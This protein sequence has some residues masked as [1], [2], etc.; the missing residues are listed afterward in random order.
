MAYSTPNGSTV[1]IGALS[2][3]NLT[4]TIATNAAPCVMTATAHGL[5]NGDYVTVL[6]SG[7]SRINEKTYRVSGVTTNTFELE[8]SDTSSVSNFPAGSGTGTV[9][10]VSSW[11][12]LTQILN[13]Q[14]TASEQQYAKYQPMDSD[15]EREIP[16]YKT[17]G[18]LDI[19]VGDDPTL[20]G[21]INAMAANDS[22]VPKPVR[23]TNK[24]GSKTLTYS[25]VSADKVAQMQVNEVQRSKVSLRHLNEANRY[26]T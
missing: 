20:A 23:I 1:D 12:P 26:A 9:Q 2:G 8:G 21:F 4:V 6:T 5:T 7:W 16:T 19:E 13:I 10:K 25:Y 17:G 18:N 22:G 15:R 24:N 11:T 3:S 14:S